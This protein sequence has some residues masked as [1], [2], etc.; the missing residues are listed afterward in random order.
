[1]LIEDAERTAAFL[2]MLALSGEGRQ[3]VA[4]DI[5]GLTHE[6]MAQLSIPLDN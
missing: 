1:M 6:D 3:F 2:K 5:L 4:S